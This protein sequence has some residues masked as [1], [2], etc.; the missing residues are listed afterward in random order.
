MIK[1]QIMNTETLGRNQGTSLL[2][3]LHEDQSFIVLPSANILQKLREQ[4]SFIHPLEL[5]PGFWALY[6]PVLFFQV[7]F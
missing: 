1:K 3:H 6:W 5:P 4:I 2:S 7:L